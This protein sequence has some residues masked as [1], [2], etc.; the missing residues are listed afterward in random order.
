MPSAAKAALSK[1]IRGLRERLL[2]ELGAT[3]AVEHGGFELLAGLVYQ[4]QLEAAG[5]S[6]QQRR[7]GSPA[8]VSAATLG[9]VLERLDQDALRPCWADSMAL[10]WVCQ[11]WNDQRR[12]AIDARLAGGGKVERHELASKTQVFTERYLVEWTVQNSLGPMWLAM[13]KRQG[14]TPWCEAR[15]TLEQLEQ[16]RTSWRAK[17]EAGE[18]GLDERM[19]LEDELEHSW[20]YYVPQPISEELVA[21]APPSLRELK[22]L[23]PAVGAGHFLIVAFELL[24]P[25]YREEAAHR[26]QLI[27]DCEIAESIVANNLHGID[28]DPRVVQVAEAALS[29]EARRLAPQARP[30][31]FNLVA[32][33]GGLGLPELDPEAPALLEL[34]AAVRSDTGIEASATRA[35]LEG[36]AQAEHLGSLLRVEGLLRAAGPETESHEHRLAEL[37]WAFLREQGAR[38]GRAASFWALAR[39]GRY[40]IVV[41]NPPYQGVAK[42]AESS[43]LEHS[44]PE[45]KADLY[46]AFL[47]RSLELVRPGG[48]SAQLTL[49]NW[50]FI[51]QYSKLRR[52]L[53]EDYDLA[54][55][56]DFDRGA[57][58]G[59]PDELV[60]VVVS[61]FWRARPRTQSLALQPTPPQDNSRDLARTRRK[62]AA[63]MCQV[64]RHAFE[65]AALERIP[66][67]PLV[68]WWSRVR[69]LAW[70]ESGPLL[71][72]RYELRYGVITTDNARF[73]RRSWE[74][75]LEPRYC[76]HADWPGA[77][78]ELRWAPYVV[79]AKGQRWIDEP[80]TVLAWAQR[81]EAMRV[82]MKH[83]YGSVSRKMNESIF[84]R[85][86]VAVSM[87]GARFS[88]RLHRYASITDGMASS[89]FD[90]DEHACATILCHLNSAR[91]QQL[92]TGLNPTLHFELRDVARLPLLPQ[93]EAEQIVA[94]LLEAFEQHEAHRETSVDYRG[95]GPSPW[96]YA[97][98]W[99]QRAVDRPAGAALPAYAPRLE[100]ELNKDHISHAL[101]VALGRFGEQGWLVPGA[102]ELERA[103]PGGILFVDATL[104]DMEETEEK[105][106]DSL[107]HPACALLH[108]KWASHPPEPE[109]GARPRAS[110]RAYLRLDFFQQVHR[111]M[112]EKRPIYWPLSS[113]R[114]TFVAHINIHRLGPCTLHGLI[115]DHLLPAQRRL[116]ARVQGQATTKLQRQL[117]EL[118]EFIAQVRMCAEQGPPSVDPQRYPKTDASYA[119]VLDDGVK[120]NAAPLWPL[121]HPQWKQPKAW[122][123][124]LC[125]AKGRKDYDWS[126]LAAAYFPERVAAKCARDPS[127]ALAHGGQPSSGSV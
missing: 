49:R 51:R 23:D 101:G 75:E 21:R 61:V 12:E 41:G 62:H 92:M 122:W 44:Y 25:L 66:D 59:I 48:V 52:Y 6:E 99:A 86:G 96:A 124:D 97:Q 102:P 63:T 57:F 110:L 116:E 38:L 4:R 79:G 119:P 30:P 69:E 100:P 64:G 74:V 85:R 83:L 46:A 90:D 106:T 16:R 91:V 9:E 113:V 78:D 40:D 125:M 37:V 114:K 19:P 2:F 65:L 112:Y 20:A 105:K 35:L 31:R 39:A 7:F 80:S 29:L 104:E 1:T 67:R 68:Y 10:G 72:D 50:M 120:I 56:G 18:V 27:H 22:L 11:F 103:L 60:S 123:R 88:A 70:F 3:Q 15:G 89:V 8:Q 26:G 95:P 77:L 117:D 32:T 82:R 42:L 98:D 81:G 76:S 115:A 127:L 28:L 13:C 94:R 109:P 121:L 54:L 33:Q 84:F 58:E 126:Q 43:E 73:T 36:L 14:W 53:L 87:I 24:V 47:I 111:S 17:R 93:P 71:G 108:E 5:L 118:R 107:A 45:G 55:L 34:C